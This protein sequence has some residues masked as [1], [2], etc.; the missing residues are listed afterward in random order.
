MAESVSSIPVET[1]PSSAEMPASM[2]VVS[3]STALKAH[4]RRLV[5]DNAVTCA[6]ISFVP[7][8]FLGS[9]GISALQLRMLSELSGLYGVPFSQNVARSL[10]AASVGGVLNS[11]L[12]RNPVSHALR[13]WVNVHLSIIALPL[14]LLTG[15]VLM[16]AYTYILGNAFVRHYEKGGAYIDFDWLLFRYELASKLGLPRPLLSKTAK[17]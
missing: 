9:V 15:P 3:S 2:P 7:A 1:L 16:A 5:R 10:V 17:T 13:D 6:G 4:A 8:P 11:A 14:R 12:A